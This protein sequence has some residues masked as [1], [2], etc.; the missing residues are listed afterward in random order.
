MNYQ[1]DFNN[2]LRGRD[3]TSTYVRGLDQY[4]QTNLYSTPAQ[5]LGSKRETYRPLFP[6][7]L[8]TYDGMSLCRPETVS[9]S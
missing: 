9:G 6:R 8:L 4:P 2:G 5:G 7:Y 1:R 3:L